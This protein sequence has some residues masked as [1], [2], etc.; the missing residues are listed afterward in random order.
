G[1]C[2]AW[3][4]ALNIS[5]ADDIL[6]QIE[7]ALDLDSEGQMI[8]SVL[9]KKIAAGA[10]HLIIDMPV[11][12][13]AKVRTPAAA[14]ALGGGFS[15][16][17]REFGLTL[18]V[19]PTDGSQ[20]VGRGIGPALEARDVL[21]V[22]QGANGAPAD[23]RERALMIA[24]GL[25]ELCGK[26]APGSGLALAASALDSGKAWRRFLRICE[27]QGGLRHPPIAQ[28]RNTLEAPEQGIVTALDNRRLARLAKLAGAPEDRAAGIEMHVRIGDV[29]PRGAPL[30]TIHAEAEGQLDY[31]L[32]Y[33]K[34]NQSMFS[35]VL[36]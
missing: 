10:T 13:T 17:A 25:L 21:A 24:A 34:A 8:A 30:C 23:L 22:L 31:A 4:G 1:G 35:L 20:P 5:P 26:I 7:H 28:Y 11:G 3:G 16:V 19:L 14:A 29:V 18:R 9:S 27:A 2:I 6:I 12:P 15:A 33:A 32:A 36:P